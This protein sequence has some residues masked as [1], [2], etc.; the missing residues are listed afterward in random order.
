MKCEWINPNEIPDLSGCKKL[1]LFGAGEGTRVLME[2]VKTGFVPGHPTLMAICDN[3]PS[4]H[5]KWFFGVEVI[6]PEELK[7]LDCDLILVTSIS[8]RDQIA[9]QLEK[10]GFVRN[11]DF[12]L[13]G[14]YPDAY[15]PAMTLIQ[16]HYFR[17][18]W[19]GADSVCL[20]VGPGGSF[21]LEILLYCYGF[22]RV[23]SIDVNRFGANYPKLSSDCYTRYMAIRNDLIAL[24]NE[25]KKNVVLE[26]FDSLFVRKND[27]LFFD[28]NRIEFLY[29]MDIC[30]LS[31]PDNTFDF[32]FSSGVLEHV[33]DPERAVSEIM[34]VLKIE[35]IALHRIITQDHRSFSAA[36]DCH[37]FSFRNY[38]K[39]AWTG[40]TTMKFYQ[41]RLLPVE[42]KSLFLKHGLGI[43]YFNIE[44]RAQIDDEMAAQFH[45]DFLVFSRA[46]LEAVNCVI[47]GIHS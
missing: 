41:N 17:L 43:E 34:R 42:W 21:S 27:H 7:A 33:K 15:L 19:P 25:S 39:E 6:H 36:S 22:N 40:S 31:L 30:S 44:K 4:L 16:E 9:D 12:F 35:G 2:G 20:N 38:S 13:V 8:G 24:T 11:R 32:I 28:Q 46:D 23:V 5:G 10:M 45:P 37:A 14:R 47:L 26:R 29:P 3:D 18:G 1:V